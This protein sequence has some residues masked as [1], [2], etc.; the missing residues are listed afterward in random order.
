MAGVCSWEVVRGTTVRSD[1][2][3]II[4]EVG[5]SLEE[6]HT[7]G[8]QKWSSNSADWE[9]FMNISDQEMQKIDINEAV[10]SLNASVCKAILKAAE[11][12][13]KKKGAKHK[14]KI[15]PRWTKECG[16]AMKCQNK[17]FE[18]LKRNHSVQN[19][20]EYKRLQANVRRIIK[21]AEKD[22]WR[23]FCNSMGR[24]TEKKNWRMIKRMNQIIRS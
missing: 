13:V 7:G 18:M 9:I 14:K 11:K 17:A 15:V 3:P 23:K 5:L 4:I 2:Y 20:I 24:E 6:Y 12:S 19:L 21:N 8:L 16:K 1:H 10:N 22:Y